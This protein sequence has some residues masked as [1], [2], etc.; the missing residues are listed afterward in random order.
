MFPN[1]PNPA[2]QSGAFGSAAQATPR[3]AILWLH[4]MPAKANPDFFSSIFQQR[5]WGEIGC[6][7]RR[8]HGPEG[9]RVARTARRRRKPVGRH[10]RRRKPSRVSA[11][12]SDEA[13]CSEPEGCSAPYRRARTPCR[14]ACGGSHAPYPADAGGDDDAR[15]RTHAR[16]AGDDEGLAFRAR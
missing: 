6:F 5:V 1:E 14:H 2:T 9:D 7:R 11:S 3:N 16:E 13:S 4:R 15:R 12:P 8:L 10:G